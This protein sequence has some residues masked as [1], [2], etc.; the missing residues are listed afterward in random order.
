MTIG[1]VPVYLISTRT[2]SLQKSSASSTKD[3]IMKIKITFRI[4][5]SIIF[6]LFIVNILVVS[7]SQWELYE[8]TNLVGSISG[9]IKQGHIFRTASGSIYEVTGLTL[10]LVLAL[11]PEV[12]VLRQGNV[13]K[14]IV[15]D[16]DEPLICSQL[17]SPSHRIQRDLPREQITDDVVESF[18]EGEFTGWDGETIF[19]LTNGQIWQQSSYAYMYHY[20]YRPKVLIYKSRNIYK[21]K[22]D[23]VSQT[24]NVRRLK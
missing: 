24:I 23:G 2:L 14:L 16:F 6:I 13:F 21:M 4:F 3:F 9:T 1:A 17:K 15:D 10:Q 5:L 18:I 20:A 12:I 8:E 11:S 7:Q 22:V 19:R